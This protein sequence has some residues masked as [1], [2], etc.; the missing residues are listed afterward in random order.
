MATQTT[1]IE[2]AG[3][4]VGWGG[5]VNRLD[6]MGLLPNQASDCLNVWDENNVLRRRRGTEEF[7]D[8]L[9]KFTDFSETS[10]GTV[11][12]RDGTVSKLSQS[13]NMAAAAG[14]DYDKPS[15]DS[16]ARDIIMSINATLISDGNVTL[17]LWT[18]DGNG[19]PQSLLATS[20]IKDGTTTPSTG[21]L[22]FYF[23]QVVITSNNL[24]VV[25]TSSSTE[26]TE[27]NFFWN[28]YN[29]VGGSHVA[30]SF[31]DP[32]WAEIADINFMLKVYIGQDADVDSLTGN[33]TNS[34]ELLNRMSSV[35]SL[36][37]E[38]SL[39]NDS[40]SVGITL[41]DGE[42]RYIQ[43][44]DQATMFVE[45]DNVAYKIEASASSGFHIVPSYQGTTGTK[46]V[47]IAFDRAIYGLVGSQIN[48]IV[49]DYFNTCPIAYKVGS[50]A[51]GFISDFVVTKKAG[52]EAAVSMFFSAQSVSPPTPK[53]WGSTTYPFTG[54]PGDHSFTGLT[55]PITSARAA[56]WYKNHLFVCG[57]IINST[58]YLDRIYY[59][60][61]GTPE[62]GYDDLRHDIANGDLIAAI[63]NK[64]YAIVATTRGTRVLRGDYYENF[65]YED[66]ELKE[67]IVSH[68][69]IC[70]GKNKSGKN[71]FY[72]ITTLGFVVFDETTYKYID[73][74]IREEIKSIDIDASS[75]SY[76]ENAKMVRFCVSID[77]TK[78]VYGYMI[79]KETWYKFDTAYTQC[80]HLPVIFT[81]LG[82]TL[83]LRDKYNKSHEVDV[84]N[85]G[86]SAIEAYYKTAPFHAAGGRRFIPWSVWIMA[87]NESETSNLTVDR[88]LNYTSDET[89]ISL[90][91]ATF[92][93]DVP[94][95]HQVYVYKGETNSMELKLSQDAVDQEFAIQSIMVELKGGQSVD[96]TV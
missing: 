33:M 76:D 56:M 61:Q 95:A 82:I 11:D 23:S 78:Y 90:R 1:P 6:R 15:G 72:G 8:V 5:L 59:S 30:G 89:T 53:I 13:F 14:G 17:E 18:R 57:V 25:L 2:I 52:E 37:C 9:F 79:E 3:G 40:H 24:C 41:D 81:N 84:K 12:V 47:Y 35:K 27:A 10:D 43:D 92:P 64:N 96:Q 67:P 21:W 85:D 66:H 74:N 49:Q 28:Y 58:E 83:G 65:E 31:T 93:D 54:E 32:N 94:V 36:S 86:G 44:Y 46:N 91:K 48:F 45:G 55:N 42:P 62:A 16:T 69:A 50:P 75:C 29:D 87:R 71:V 26:G 70:L 4:Q 7:S 77:G 73:D 51:F 88:I 38:A 34:L 63:S 39:T 20:S 60:G 22:S 68:N 19:L 80:V